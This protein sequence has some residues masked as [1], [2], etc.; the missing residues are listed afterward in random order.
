MKRICAQE[1][2]ILVSVA[3]LCIIQAPHASGQVRSL[4][5]PTE[6]QSKRVAVESNDVSVT[7]DI[8]YANHTIFNPTTGLDD[9]VHL[10]SYNGGLVGPT[11]RV[12]PGDT[13]DV[14]LIN[15]LP[16]DDP[17]CPSPP[18]DH[19]TPN[20]FNSTNL[21]THGLHVSPAGNSDNVLIETPPGSTFD[22]EFVLP[23]DHPA[24][25]FWYH[26][27]RHGST[28]LQVSS[29]MAGAL[30]VEGH[31]SIF[32]KSRNGVADV[33]T[34]LKFPGGEPF[35][36]RV[37]LFEQIAYAC[38]ANRDGSPD[39]DCSGKTGVIEQYGD[40]FGPGTWPQ[41]GRYTLINGITQPTWA[42]K[43]GR[44]E[45]W[46]LIHGG[47]RDT[48]KMEIVKS[49]SLGMTA[50]AFAARPLSL[51][52]QTNWVTENCQVDKPLT[53]WE[54]AADGITRQKFDAK[55]I[56]VLQ[57]GYRSDIL[58]VFYEPGTYCVIDEQ[59]P[60]DATVNAQRK[61]RR[62]LGLVRVE[63]A[64]VADTGKEYLMS[65]LLAG[66]AD[67]PDAVK[68]NLR[69]LNLTDYSPLEGIS[70]KD[71]IGKQSVTL[72][73]DVSKTPPAFEIDG[74]P[75]DPS[76][77]DR[78][79]ILNSVDEWTLTSDF[80]NHPFHI[81]VNPFQVI[82]ILN[83]KGQPVV[84]SNANCLDKDDSGNLDT[85]YC[86][87]IG[88][89]RDTIFVKKGYVLT[90]RSR[91]TSFI[92]EFVLHCHILDHEDQGMMQNVE[93]VPTAPKMQRQH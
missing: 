48:V 1:I 64:A 33:D 39:W 9:K 47:V 17:S 73:I 50:L 27:H 13:L 75:Y 32:D 3:V 42:A 83:P 66:N 40:Q 88:I 8:G 87:Q 19:N 89:F 55:T 71:V 2:R 20:C 76:R 78:T 63:G 51:E 59:A 7:L 16:A 56:N 92:G 49:K 37:L 11:I 68:A 70:D 6:I 81:H 62:L 36:D 29:G 41:S 30:I 46:R 10:R 90:I 77:I 35:E 34:I 72:N 28:A 91:Y 57:P 15:S 54:F 67:L 86:D 85:Q 24:G 53:Q 5:E 58:A 82:K 23:K 79:L 93:I 31:R 69:D 52:A 65:Q 26:S 84:D 22:Y 74:K 4:S 18:S 61:D 12:K 80:V 60:A 25:T 14:K 45:R 21:H 43:T 44:I 38:G